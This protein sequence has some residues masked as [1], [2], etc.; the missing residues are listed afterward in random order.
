MH[1]G[2]KHLSGL[3]LLLVACSSD[4]ALTP[5]R[6]S[7]AK[8]AA[9]DGK[10]TR[11]A[12]VERVADGIADSFAPDRAVWYGAQFLTSA[13]PG[14]KRT[15]CLSTGC[16]PYASSDK[17]P[18]YKCATCHGGNGACNPNGAASTKRDHTATS[19]C[20][21]AGC[22]GTAIVHPNASTYTLDVQCLTCHFAKRGGT[23]DC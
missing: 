3:T 23:P 9:A 16:H 8:D 13:H 10:T 18:V 17:P 2:L 11:D 1:A 20:T 21:T 12:S 4:T 19:A 22:H 6:V 7:P 15:D 5:D 14:W